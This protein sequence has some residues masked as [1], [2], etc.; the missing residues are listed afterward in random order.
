MEEVF[1]FFIV[2]PKPDDFSPSSLNDFISLETDVTLAG[3]NY[4]MV[5]GE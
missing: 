5:R 2:G 4:D 3:E 1:D